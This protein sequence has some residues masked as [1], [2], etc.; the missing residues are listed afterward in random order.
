MD[1]NVIFIEKQ[2]FRQW[3]VI[4]IIIAL[5]ALTAYGI[6]SQLLIG[7]PFGQHPMSDFW[8]NVTA[9]LVFLLSL[10]ILILRLETHVSSDG[11]SVRFFPLHLKFKKFSWDAIS[12]CYVREYAP[13]G[14]FGGWGLRIGLFGQ[15]NA[16]NVAGNKGLQ[17]QFKNGKKLLI[18]TQ[19]P[20]LIFEALEKIKSTK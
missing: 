1:S 15:G 13:I 17:I 10:F 6:I 3:W 4:L 20:D 8:L 7:K 9:F 16:W 14:E 18:G 2:K 11:I 5:N 12:E 19:K